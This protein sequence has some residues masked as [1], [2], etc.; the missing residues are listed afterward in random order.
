[1]EKVLEKEVGVMEKLWEHYDLFADVCNIDGQ[2]WIIGSFVPHF[3]STDQT[4]AS[5]VGD[6]KEVV[7]EIKKV[8]SPVYVSAGK[9]PNIDWLIF[10]LL[11]KYDENNENH[12]TLLK[13][14]KEG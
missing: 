6:E 7:E 9:I 8:F 2:T 3:G 10:V 11:I 13:L 12:R 5:L 14:I 4:F 1:M